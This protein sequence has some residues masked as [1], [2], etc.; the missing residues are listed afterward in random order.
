MQEFDLPAPVGLLGMLGSVSPQAPAKNPL[1]LG[2]EWD[3]RND[4]VSIGHT[5]VRDY[6]LEAAL[7]DQGR[8]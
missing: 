1:A 3:A 5:M 2:L 7:L 8:L 4:W 6:R